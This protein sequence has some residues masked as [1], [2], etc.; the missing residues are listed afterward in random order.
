MLLFVGLSTLG[1]R[2]AFFSYIIFMFAIIFSLKKTFEYDFPPSSCCLFAWVY[3]ATRCMTS[4]IASRF[5]G[6]A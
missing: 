3:S 1:Y 4:L 6:T 2:T 5:L